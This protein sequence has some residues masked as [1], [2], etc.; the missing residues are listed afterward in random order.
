MA[1]CTG[2]KWML[3]VGLSPNVFCSL[4]FVQFKPESQQIPYHGIVPDKFKDK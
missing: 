3:N 2:H 1:K 4:C